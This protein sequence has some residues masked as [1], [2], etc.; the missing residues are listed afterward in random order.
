MLYRITAVMQVDLE[1]FVNAETED[2]ALD[3][4]TE[5]PD[6]FTE[7]GDG[8]WDVTWVAEWEAGDKP[9]GVQVYQA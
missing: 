3:Y 1:L 8:A 4:A 5:H 9:G 2:E 7:D 6:L